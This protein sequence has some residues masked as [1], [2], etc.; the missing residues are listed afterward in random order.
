MTVNSWKS[1]VE[2]DKGSFLLLYET[3]YQA[4]F[5]YGFTLSADREL[6]KDCIQ[7]L[8]VE[9]WNTRSTLNKDVRNVRSYLFTWLRRKITLELSRLAKES[10]FNDATEK[11]ASIQASYEELLIAFQQSAE[12]KEQLRRALSKLTRKQLETIKLKFFENLSYR[13]I[14]ERQSITPRTVYNTIYEAIRQ[15]RE[16]MKLLLIHLMI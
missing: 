5:C 11:S 4:L 15:L 6:T 7:E 1:M 3:C 14:A 9:I 12:K 10:A 16:S 13:A 8:F 2:G